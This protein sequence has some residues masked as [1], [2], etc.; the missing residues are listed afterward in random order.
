VRFFES[1]NPDALAEAMFDVLT[2]DELRRGMVARA[3]EYAS[4][5][6]WENRKADYL[7]LIDSL[8]LQSA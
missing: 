4:R 6:S 1:G 5:N 8:A 3:S 7:Q 2:N